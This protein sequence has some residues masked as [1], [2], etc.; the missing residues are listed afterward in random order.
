PPPRH[1]RRCRQASLAAMTLYIAPI[2]CTSWA[3]R[4]CRPCLRDCLR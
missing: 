3:G 4:R 1:C 2:P